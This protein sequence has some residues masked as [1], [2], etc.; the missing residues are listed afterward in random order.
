MSWFE[1][2]CSDRFMLIGCDRG[3]SVAFVVVAA[4]VV[5]SRPVAPPKWLFC[6]WVAATVPMP[7]AKWILDKGC[8]TGFGSEIGNVL[9]LGGL[10]F[11]G[12]Y[13]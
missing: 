10:S 2:R 7:P 4:A 12:P 9:G 8:G 11:V 13:I 3:I 6:V 5:D 1:F